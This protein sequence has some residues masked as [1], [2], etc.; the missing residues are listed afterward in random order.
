MA[1]NWSKYGSDPWWEEE[2]ASIG[3]SGRVAFATPPGGRT[4]AFRPRDLLVPTARAADAQAFLSKR[5]WAR[6]VTVDRTP[7]GL[8]TR[9]ENVP[10][11]IRAVEELRVQL[12]VTA[13]PNHVFFVHCGDWC[14]PHPAW[15]GAYGYRRR[16]GFNPAEINP[17]EINPNH[18][19]RTTGVRRSSARPATPPPAAAP[20]PPFTGT[21]RVF[22]LDTGLAKN[23]VP[24]EPAELAALAA[25]IDGERVDVPDF[26]S[27]DL[28]DPAA[29]HGTFIAGVINRLAPGCK[30]TVERVASIY[31]DVTEATAA[32]KILNLAGGPGTILNLSFGGYAYDDNAA[33]LA[34][35]IRTFQDSGGVV[36]ASAGNDGTCCPTYPAAL[37]GVVSVGALAAWGPAPFTNYGPWVRACAPGVDLL[38]LFFNFNGALGLGVDEV[39]DDAFTGW[40]QWSGTSF[41]APV[42]VGALVRTMVSAQV[43]A[44]EAVRRVVDAPALFRLPSLGTVVNV[45]S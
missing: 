33:V 16:G 44:A 32:A 1:D 31:G 17:A 37:P 43:P 45:A 19:W 23:G 15:R 28:L 14:P 5:S 36:V 41:A 10:D 30:I 25:V 3:W 29:G 38:S 39:D 12:G 34:D 8:F 7:V 11:P 6:E 22:V 27:N 4:V 42:V 35:A 2:N 9:L 13:Q 21:P 20:P 18:P 26:D 24:S 40:A